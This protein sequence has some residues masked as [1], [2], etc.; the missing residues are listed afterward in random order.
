MRCAGFT[1]LEAVVAIVI[2]GILAGMVS[3]FIT[4]PIQ[5][6]FDASRRA[7]MADVADV[8][9]RRVTRDVSGALP[10]SLRTVPNGFEF[11]MTSGGGRY[12]DAGDGSTG[13]NVL[14]FTSAAATS[15]DVLGP[16]PTL[17]AGASGD[18]IVVYNL[19]AGY[20]PANAYNCSATPPG[21][22]IA[23]VSAVA[24]STVTL[25]TNV[26]GAQTPPLPSPGSRFHVVPFAEKVVRYTCTGGVLTRFSNC[27]IATPSVCGAGAVLAGSA[28]QSI[29]CTFDFTTAALG[30]SGLLAV[31]LTVTDVASSEAVTLY[32]EI[33]VDNSP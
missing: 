30:R 16:V 22:N 23:R 12:R 5:G 7:E 19:G 28:A 14:S 9:L 1:L 3:V 20:E 21:C 4:G 33:H 11:I 8:A 27:S 18:S 24:G 15:F 31:Q 13:G 25:S 26:F 29:A 6:Y 10:N 32:R 17:V 2:T